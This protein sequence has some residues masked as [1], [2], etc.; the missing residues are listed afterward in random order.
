MIDKVITLENNL[1][2]YVIDEI[3]LD[4]KNYIMAVLIDEEKETI[5]DKYLVCNIERGLNGNKL[6]NID[7]KNEYEKVCNILISRLRNNKAN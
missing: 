2:Y 4:D 1:K 6:K 7:D 5:E 3:E